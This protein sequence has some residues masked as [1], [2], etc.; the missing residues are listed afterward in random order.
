MMNPDHSI[1]AETICDALGRRAIA[2]AI[3]VTRSAVSNYS[4]AGTFPAAWYLAI[5]AMC[6]ERNLDCPEVIFNFIAP[7]VG[8]GIEREATTQ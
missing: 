6:E 8:D 5:K 1:T 2:E 4:A 3:G 7:P